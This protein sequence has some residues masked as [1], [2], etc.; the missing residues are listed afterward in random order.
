MTNAAG[1]AEHSGRGGPRLQVIEVSKAFPGVQALD[2]VSLEV[3]PGEVHALVGENGAGKS[4]LMRLIAGVETPDEGRIF[5]DGQLLVNLDE[6]QAGRLGISMVHQERSL[7]PG[8]SIAENVFAARQPTRWFGTID[9]R[10]MR[11]RTQQIL[12]E[13]Q[14]DLPPDRLV[15]ELSPAQQQMV[16]IA[17]ALSRQLRLLI[18]DEPTAALTLAETEHLFEVVR[19]L[20]AQGVSIVYISHRLAE[21][22]R[23]AQ[24][25]TVLKDGQVTGVRA[26]SEVDEAEL[27]RLMVGRELSF[28]PDRRRVLTDAP[29][30]LQVE[31]LAA[32]PAVKRASLTVR[33]GEIVCLAGLVGAGRSELCQVIFGARRATAGRILFEGREVRFS[34]P[35][36]AREAGIAMVPEDRKED[37]L[38]LEMSLVDNIIAAHLDAVSRHGLL[39]SRRSRALAERYVQELRIASPSLAQPVLNLSGGNQQKVLLA[40]WFVRRPRLLIVD[41]PTRG[42]DVGVRADIY[43]V[44]RDFAASG[45]ALLVV[46]S[47]LPEVLTLAHRIIIMSEGQTVAELD[48]SEADEEKILALASPGSSKKEVNVA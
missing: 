9:W 46:S 30:V 45:V 10:T 31:N 42:V 37:G 13:L 47:D 12:Q 36:E 6:Q 39:S 21:V 43:R 4:T 14:V 28:T 15:G 25:I 22:F 18:L 27:V 34:H 38:F 48:A 2:R 1:S 8:L 23:I 20:A 16:E 5:L 44:L 26:V 7:V 17:K 11:K 32:P 3:W 40:K 19:H 35:A 24:R 29:V 41:E 33:A